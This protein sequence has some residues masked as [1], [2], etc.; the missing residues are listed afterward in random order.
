MTERYL[1]LSVRAAREGARR[2]LAVESV[3][4]A[5]KKRES[6]C[7]RAD[8]AVP[9]RTP[10]EI[11]AA[12]YEQIKREH[13]LCAA[14]DRGMRVLAAAGGSRVQVRQKL[15][16]RGVSR[17]T[18]EDATQALEKQG[19]L[20]E[21]QSALSA[22]RADLR[23]LWGDRRILSDLHAKG[24]GDAAVDAVKEFLSEEDAAARCRRLIE[25]RHLLAQYEGDKL[26]A[27]LLRYG[28]TRTDIRTALRAMTEE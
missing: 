7:L 27:A 11:D 2:I 9:A 24:Y 28:Y 3:S 17:E 8:F 1:L 22:A 4:D 14:L 6:F 19:Y 23:K 25:K 21:T 20:Q 15:I 18:A 26:I 13:A 16:A 5:E 12:Y 10:C